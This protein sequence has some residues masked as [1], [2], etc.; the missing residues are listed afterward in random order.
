MPLTDRLTLTEV[1]RGILEQTSVFRQEDLIPVPCHPDSLA[2]AYALKIDGKVAPL[3]S[4]IDPKI[5]ID[6]GR[7]T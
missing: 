1:R 2:M 3:T 7:N 5:L 6:G 4:L